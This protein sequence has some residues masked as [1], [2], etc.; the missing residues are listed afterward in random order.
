MHLHNP[1]LTRHEFVE[2]L[3]A[4]FD[5]S[6]DARLSKTSM[7]LELE[8]LLRERRDHGETTVL[9]VDEAQSLPLDLLEEVRL[10]AN[11]ETDDAKLL[12]VIIAG[13][14]ELS[15]RLN[16]TRLRQLKQRV[17]LRCELRPLTEKETA[18]YLAGRIAAAGGAGSEVFT[19]E[20]VGLIHARAR[21]IPRT[22]SVI[23]DNALLGG[24]AAGQRP[25]G[26]QIVRDVCRDF[27]LNP[28]NDAA[29]AAAR[30]LLGFDA[31][32]QPLGARNVLGGPPIQGP[33]PAALAN[34]AALREKL[35]RRATPA[36]NVGVSSGLAPEIPADPKPEPVEP[37]KPVK[38][39][40]RLFTFFSE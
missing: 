10:L 12:S 17:A 11:M 31:T 19:R 2:M 37:E 6:N 7:L 22:I 18:G 1:T 8:G 13:Q 26:T 21:G 4:H 14:P 15:V 33:D 30:A 32:G 38:P 39:K 5:L 29:Q 20:A 34:F 40:N 23:A 16:E 25:V 35:Q 3:A 27:D 28:S 36:E 24:F 9:I